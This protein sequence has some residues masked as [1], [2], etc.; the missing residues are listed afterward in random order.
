MDIKKFKDKLLDCVTFKKFMTYEMAAHYL[1]INEDINEI[2]PTIINYANMIIPNGAAFIAT[3]TGKYYREI[4]VLEYHEYLRKVGFT[5]FPSPI[6]SRKP[7]LH[8]LIDKN[9]NIAKNNKFEEID[10][11]VEAGIISKDDA[12]IVRSKIT[13]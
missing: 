11:L 9:I 8:F 12:E 10:R 1:G 7:K 4:P 5:S 6:D 3:K 13:K 2:I